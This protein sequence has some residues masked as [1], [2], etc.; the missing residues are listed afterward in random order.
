QKLDEK[1]VEKMRKEAEN[2]AEEDKKRKESIELRNNAESVIYSTEKMLQE[3]GDKTD[4]E[5]KEKIE[6]AV[7]ELKD[8]VEKDDSSLIKKEL[9]E[10]NKVAQE[11]GMKMYQE[12]MKQQQQK[13][14]KVDDKDDVVEGEVVDEDN[15]KKDK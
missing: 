10:V 8:A 13:E 12:A 2:F 3:Y 1:E 6:K 14:E 5:V 9:E 4:P 11:L 15:G 7:K